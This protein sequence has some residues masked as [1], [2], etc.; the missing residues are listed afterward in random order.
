[1]KSIEEK[2]EEIVETL[3]ELGD[4]LLQYQLLLEVAS[5]MQPLEEEQRT[6]GT[7]V[8][9]CQ[10]KTWLSCSDEKNHIHIKAD[11]E[12][13]IVKGMVGL[14]ILILDEHELSDVATSSIDFIERTDLRKQI[15]VDRFHGMRSMI[16]K[17]QDY[18]KSHSSE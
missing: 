3:N 4:R 12:T 17:I 15:S 13:L 11:S 9:S 7:L 1:M 6:K 18:A 16:S 14:V 8:R 2:Q 10:A 5:S